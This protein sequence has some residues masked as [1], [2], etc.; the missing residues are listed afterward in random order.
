MTGL[1]RGPSWPITQVSAPMALPASQIGIDPAHRFLEL[2]PDPAGV[3]GF[4]RSFV[5]ANPALRRLLAA[6][7][8]A[9]VHPD[10]RARAER[11]WTA[12]VAGRLRTVDVEVR[13]RGED[14]AWRWAIVSAVAD[15]DHQLVY[16]IAKDVNARRESEQHMREAEERFRSAFESAGVGMAI[17]GLDGRFCRVNP[18][19]A[20]MLGRTPAD[21]VGVAVTAVTHP[22]DIAADRG[23][24]AAMIRGD[25]STYRTEKRYLATDGTPV[26]VALSVS[27]LRRP[28]G[29]AQEFISQMADISERRAAQVALADSERRFRTLAASSPAGIFAADRRGQITYSNDRFAE[30]FDLRGAEATGLRWLDHVHPDDR[31]SVVR[32]GLQGSAGHGPFGAEARVRWRDDS[33]RWVRFSVAPVG[34]PATG[35]G[36]FVG[37]VE[38]VT[39]A[40]RAASELSR[41]ALHDALTGLPN[42]ALFLDRLTQALARARRRGTIVGVLFLDLDRFKVVNDSLGHAA[43]DR[44]L[45]DVAARLSEGLRPADTLARFGGDELTVLCEE[46]RGEDDARLVAE[47]LIERFAE[48]FVLS[49]GEV[50][51]EGSVGIAL[52]SSGAERPED[53]IRDADAAMYRAKERGKARV[54][55]F[56]DHMRE[57][58]RERLATE[59]QLR[60]A[61]GG[62]G[63]GAEHIG[64]ELRVHYQPVVDL[65]S[66]RVQG[67]EALVRWQHPERGLLAP[68]EFVELAE[69]IGLIGRIDRWVLAQACLQLGAWQRET[70]RSDLQMG[71]NLSPRQLVMPDIVSVIGEALGAGGIRPDRLVVE[72]TERTIMEVGPVT[73]ET[74]SELK[75]LG[76]RIAIDDFGTGYSS[77]AHLRRVPVDIIK[78]DRSFTADIG[79]PGRDGVLAE[80]IL[81][82]ANALGLRTVAEGIELTTQRDALM[83]LGCSLGQGYL[84]AKPLPAPLIPALLA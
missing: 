15:A 42:R 38:D 4:D 76:V 80:A 14:G 53:L 46:L 19:L 5:D 45:I 12:L 40:K 6:G 55:L 29:G 20:E 70:G 69:E 83:A 61:L 78:I 65:A 33:T 22:D 81:S 82:L 68:A 18:A 13:V 36:Q 79:L 49:E 66:G 32:T 62:Q 84:W 35:A 77:L 23:A 74:L 44:L 58:A 72:I 31:D 34:D 28:D 21:L 63:T 9:L 64:D 26:W 37:T 3:A 59:G 25:Q 57:T 50:F 7:A 75:G 52:S 48:P 51:L 17:T 30:L 39:D 73:S 11:M 1:Q 43:G 24:M 27:I 71:V 67:F 47:R 8:D 2:T 60:R 54:E 41:L 56:D 16:A 10:D